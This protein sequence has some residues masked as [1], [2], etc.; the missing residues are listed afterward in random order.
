MCSHTSEQA[1]GATSSWATPGTQAQEQTPAEPGGGNPHLSSEQ[2][3]LI[4][5]LGSDQLGCYTDH[6]ETNEKASAGHCPQPWLLPY[7]YGGGSV[8]VL[9]CLPG[10]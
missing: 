3:V 5:R 2:L 6:G 7:F 1:P 8:V 9:W 4:T 10:T